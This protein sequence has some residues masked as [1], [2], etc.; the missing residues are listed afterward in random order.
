MQAK[1]LADKKESEFNHHL[2]EIFRSVGGRGCLASKRLRETV[3][4]VEVCVAVMFPV[5]GNFR[6]GVE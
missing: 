6:V 5:L 2:A 4:A 1:L 3:A